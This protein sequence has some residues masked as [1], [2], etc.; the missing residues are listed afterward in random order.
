MQ[1]CVQLIILL[2]SQKAMQVWG[3]LSLCATAVSMVQTSMCP[4]NMPS[5][6]PPSSPVLNIILWLLLIYHFPS[7]S[8]LL[9]T[10]YHVMFLRRGSTESEILV[11]TLRSASHLDSWGQQ[12][13]LSFGTIGATEPLPWRPVWVTCYSA[14][15]ITCLVLPDYPHQG[16]WREELA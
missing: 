4:D 3:Q 8:I 10:F 9:F 6:F 14:P 5:L 13:P 15:I 12:V 1:T 7:S 11:S 16:E 2:L